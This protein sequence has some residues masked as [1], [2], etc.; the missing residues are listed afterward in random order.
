MLIHPSI[1]PILTPKIFPSTL[2]VHV[3]VSPRPQIPSPPPSSHSHPPHLAQS[4][5]RTAAKASPIALQTMDE[6]VPN[7]LFARC[8]HPCSPL[9][10]VARSFSKQTPLICET[11]YGQRSPLEPATPQRAG[12]LFPTGGIDMYVCTYVCTQSNMHVWRCVCLW[13]VR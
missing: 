10:S 8:R 7:I 3:R 12:C 5:R 6:A 2:P 4:P 1:H 11:C 9:S 13:S